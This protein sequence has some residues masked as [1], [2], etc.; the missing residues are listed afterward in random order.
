MSHKL[1]TEDDRPRV[2]KMRSLSSDG[3]RSH[4]AKMHSRNRRQARATMRQARRNAWTAIDE[5]RAA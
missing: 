5:L 2:R 1:T 4:A 3:T